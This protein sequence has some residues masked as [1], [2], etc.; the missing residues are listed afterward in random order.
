MYELVQRTRRTVGVWQLMTAG[1]GVGNWRTGAPTSCEI[2]C[3]ALSKL[4]R[5]LRRLHARK[6]VLIGADVI[7][8]MCVFRDANFRH[9]E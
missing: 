3:I 5:A 1:K 9:D 6:Q 4:S 2:T 8:S 7:A